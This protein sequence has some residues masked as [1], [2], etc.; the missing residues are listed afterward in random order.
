MDGLSWDEAQLRLLLQH[1]EALLTGLDL[2]EEEL[3]QA[4]TL[5]LQET[6]RNDSMAKEKDKKDKAKKTAASSSSSSIHGWILRRTYTSHTAPTHSYAC[7]T[8]V[9]LRI[10]WSP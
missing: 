1:P 10:R 9:L 7:H 2:E 8:Q 6:K 3:E 5:A 4:Y